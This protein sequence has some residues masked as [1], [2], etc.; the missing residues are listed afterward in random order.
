MNAV[1]KMMWLMTHM[2]QRAALILIAWIF[3]PH[4]ASAPHSDPSTLA[5]P[6]HARAAISSQKESP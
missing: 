3:W 5:V 2:H 4:H 6:T 1:I